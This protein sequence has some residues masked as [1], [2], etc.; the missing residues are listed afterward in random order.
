MELDIGTVDC[1][2]GVWYSLVRW[3]LCNG[4]LWTGGCCGVAGLRDGLWYFLI[5]ICAWCVRV[6]RCFFRTDGL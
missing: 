3:E 2:F 6:V 4:G 5:S 1:R